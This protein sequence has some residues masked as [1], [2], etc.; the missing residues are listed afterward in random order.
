MDI[1]T[2]YGTSPIRDKKE[3]LGMSAEIVAKNHYAATGIFRSLYR[4]G[5]Y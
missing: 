1:K 5:G 4:C 2:V 3:A